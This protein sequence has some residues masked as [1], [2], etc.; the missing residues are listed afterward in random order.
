[1][2]VK[3]LI[4]IIETDVYEFHDRAKVN[5][6]IIYHL[7]PKAR[8]AY[9]LNKNMTVRPGVVKSMAVMVN[10]SPGSDNV[11]YILGESLTLHLTKDGTDYIFTVT[12]NSTCKIVVEIARETLPSP[13]VGKW[14]IPID[15]VVLEESVIKIHLTFSI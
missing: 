15:R 10:T 3:Y 8:L 7:Q 13:S 4:K 11:V 6:A 12:P 14:T 9:P 1:M 5:E 2:N